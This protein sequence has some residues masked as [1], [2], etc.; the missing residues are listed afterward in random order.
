[1]HFFQFDN[2]NIAESNVGFVRW[3]KI[4][5]KQEE[6]IFPEFF[7]EFSIYYSSAVNNQIILL[8]CYL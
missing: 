8:H 4:G 1:M 7:P 3:S 6:A 5:F 2:I